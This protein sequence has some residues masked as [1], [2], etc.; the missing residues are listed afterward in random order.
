MALLTSG[1]LMSAPESG[2]RAAD[3]LLM[4]PADLIVEAIHTLAAREQV[5]LA[6]LYFEEL[7]ATAVASVLGLAHSEVL[8]ICDRAV[9]EIE[10]AI[11]RFKS[12]HLYP[13]RTEPFSA[14][15]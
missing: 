2:A 3:L 4:T 5:V 6:L 9:A 14:L 11:G 10:V 15:V 13:G 8:S 7:E 1:K 12:G